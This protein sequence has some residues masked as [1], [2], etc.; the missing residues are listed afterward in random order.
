MELRVSST[1]ASFSGP[2]G[3]VS[4]FP[5]SS[6]S[7]SASDVAPGCPVTRI[8]RLAY[9]ESSGRPESSPSGL[10]LG[11][12]SGLPR[13]QNFLPASGSVS[14]LPRI[15][16]PLA[17]PFG[18]SSGCP[19]SHTP[20][21]RRL[22]ILRSPRLLRLR[23]CRSTSSGFPESCFC[24]WADDDSPSQLE[25][26]ILD[27]RPWMNL[28]VQSGLAHSRNRYALAQIFHK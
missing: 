18:G 1:L 14:R 22:R 24:G 7:S 10:A 27:S 2:V 28:R 25:L 17:T 4:G 16:S 15:L 12:T 23:L 13:L 5:V 3:E 19:E 21:R 8:F 6:L 26:C 11:S 9:G 20:R